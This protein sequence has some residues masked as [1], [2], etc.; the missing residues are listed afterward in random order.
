MNHRCL[1]ALIIA[2]ALHS[3]T[4]AQ[5]VGVPVYSEARGQKNDATITQQANVLR[6]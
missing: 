3:R 6:E 1:L 4:Y 5:A 2:L